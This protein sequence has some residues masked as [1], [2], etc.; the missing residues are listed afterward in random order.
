MMRGL[1]QVGQVNVAAVQ[2][3]IRAPACESDLLHLKSSGY[4]SRADAHHEQQRTAAVY[5]RCR[6]L[7]VI[8]QRSLAVAA[9]SAA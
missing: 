7:P 6:R 5:G 1:G 8:A 4:S 9:L 2:H 3:G